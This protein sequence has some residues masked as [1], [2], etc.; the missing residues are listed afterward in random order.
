MSAPSSQT[1]PL[2]P[3]LY[4]IL[5]PALHR[6]ILAHLS[7]QAIHA[8][9]YHIVDRMYTTAN[10]VLPGQL[11]SLRFRSQLVGGQGVQGKGKGKEVEGQ[12]EERWVHTLAYISAPLRG[13]EYS[14]A[15]VRALLAIEVQDESTAEEIEQFIDVLG[16]RHTHTYTLSGHLLH[17]PIPIPTS[18]PLT[19]HLSITR[20]STSS[21]EAEESP[22]KN[23]PYLVQLRPSRPVHAI[24]QRGDLSLM[25]MVGVMRVMAGR[26]DG[27]EWSTGAAF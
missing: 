2:E 6:P 3:T 1:A 11:R 9:A 17:L 16:F 23:E 27:L 4:A 13:A 24:A 19:L 10:P 8:E 25:D 7:L 5:P 12:G 14:E 15:A 26:V 20:I 21:S 22:A 18:T